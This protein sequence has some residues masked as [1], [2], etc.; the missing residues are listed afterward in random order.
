MFNASEGQGVITRF[1]IIDN[2][3]R[4][5]IVVVIAVEFEGGGCG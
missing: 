4:I 3:R 2:D 5:P 1:V